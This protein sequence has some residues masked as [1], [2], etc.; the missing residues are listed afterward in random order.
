MCSVKLEELTEQAA[1]CSQSSYSEEQYAKRLEQATA[2]LRRQMQELQDQRELQY[3]CNLTAMKQEVSAVKDELKTRLSMMDSI[4]EK[5][6]VEKETEIAELEQQHQL[7][8][9]SISESQ[10]EQVSYYIQCS[11]QLLISHLA[12]SAE[13][14]T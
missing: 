4:Y 7:K 9:L 8:L 14:Y 1:A 5:L 3:T 10:E 12:I 2:E 13:N 11:I 6:R